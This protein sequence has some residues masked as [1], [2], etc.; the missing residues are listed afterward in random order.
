MNNR[1]FNTEEGLL[2]ITSYPDPEK[3]IK[4]L[5]AVAWH[6]QKT[7]S[8]ISEESPVV[9]LAEKIKGKTVYSDKKDLLVRPVWERGYA[10]SLFRIIPQA[11]KYS[12]IRNV[13]FQFEFNIF[14]GTTPLLALIIL[15]PILKLLGKNIYFELHQV[16]LDIKSLE[17]HVNIKNIFVQKIFNLALKL[18][19]II[20]GKFSVNIIVFEQDLKDRLAKYIKP[21]K[22]TILPL[23]VDTIQ[24][25]DRI[26]SRKKLELSDTDFTVVVFGFINWYKGSDW[27]AKLFAQYPDKNINLILAGGE[28]PTL[29]SK[30][31]Y[32]KFY[33]EIQNIAATAKNVKITGFISDI[34]VQIYF[35]AADIIVLPYRVFMSASGPF[36]FA[37]TYKK[38]VLLSDALVNY[39][40]SS[41][42]QE[43]LNEVD[44]STSDLFFDLKSTKLMTLI[45]EAKYNKIFLDKLTLFSKK[46]AEKRSTRSI[47][48][49]YLQLFKNTTYNKTLSLTFTPLEQY[50]S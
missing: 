35:A 32:Q 23:S 7:L 40:K 25:P 15:L 36:S 44:L 45:N 12:R 48:Q 3:G 43:V 18:F 42:V 2:V 29:K 20:I 31:Y 46:L 33:T 19:Y 21:E 16:V 13:L 14:G 41:D 17:K 22:I 39:T 50:N 11:L 27:I 49:K 8:A 34:N 30:S 6:S 26:T 47:T 1:R 24:L 38:P 4:E 37:L 28:N 9:V 10:L 5:N